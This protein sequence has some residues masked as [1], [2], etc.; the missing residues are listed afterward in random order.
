VLVWGTFVWQGE[1][2]IPASTIFGLL[3][4]GVL[5]VL[6]VG[7]ILKVINIKKSIHQVL[8]SIGLCTFG[9]VL[10][11]VHVLIFDK[12]FLKKGKVR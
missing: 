6:G 3:L 1:L 2:K 5:G 8:V 4:A 9:A 10:T 12:L 7:W 11:W